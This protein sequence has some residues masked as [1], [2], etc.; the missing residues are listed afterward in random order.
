METNARRAAETWT[1]P[2]D[3]ACHMTTANQS[4]WRAA[5]A[6]A[7]AIAYWSG[8]FGLGGISAAEIEPRDLESPPRRLGRRRRA[9]SGGG[10]GGSAMDSACDCWARPEDDFQ[11][12]KMDLRTLERS[13][14]APDG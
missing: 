12:F 10:R 7:F 9:T 14:G 1:Y 4:D 5:R 11:L 2:I 8:R 3:A 6:F 13:P